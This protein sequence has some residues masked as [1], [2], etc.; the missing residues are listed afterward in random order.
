MAAMSGVTSALTGAGG[1]ITPPVM[2]SG[3]ATAGASP[4]AKRVALI[5]PLGPTD[6]PTLDM[7]TAS[8]LI[9]ELQKQME[10]LDPWAT[11][12]QVAI[13]DHAMLI[14]RARDQRQGHHIQA[15]ISF[16][17]LRTEIVAMSG[18]HDLAESDLRR[19][20][21]EGAERDKR[22]RV[23]LDKMA[24]TVEESHDKLAVSVAILPLQLGVGKVGGGW[25]RLV[26]RNG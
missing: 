11:S 12:V 24:A 23:E 1:S 4:N 22:L 21:D 7:P 5:P 6:G 26:R 17:K 16:E 9:Y 15:N 2:T 14:D 13:T 20:H 8:K 18:R 3:A 25:S 10:A 19:V